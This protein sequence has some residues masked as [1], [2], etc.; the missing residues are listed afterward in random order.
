MTNCSSLYTLDLHANAPYSVK[1][2]GGYISKPVDEG[3]HRLTRP[4]TPL[5]MA[6]YSYATIGCSNLGEHHKPD[7]SLVPEFPQTHKKTKHRGATR[8]RSAKEISQKGRKRRWLTPMHVDQISKAF[9]L[10]GTRR[11]VPPYLE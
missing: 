5:A 7:F 10:R 2:K 9:L 11:T 1:P 6:S 4:K 8:A 3:Q